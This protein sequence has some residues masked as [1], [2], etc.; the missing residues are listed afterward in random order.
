M[1]DNDKEMKVNYVQGAL[2]KISNGDQQCLSENEK[3]ALKQLI[4]ALEQASNEA[5]LEEPEKTLIK[6]TLEKSRSG[7][8]SLED[9]IAIVKLLLGL[10]DLWDLL[11][12][13]S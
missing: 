12:D 1:K 2:K 6:Q 3:Q 8:L 11:K 13:Y 7:R 4:T 9:L 5:S 10:G